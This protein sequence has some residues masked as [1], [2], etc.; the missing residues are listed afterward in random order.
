MYLML[1]LLCLIHLHLFDLHTSLSE[2]SLLFIILVV[3]IEA[4][5]KVLK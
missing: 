4:K 2:A 5:T 1:L 3:L